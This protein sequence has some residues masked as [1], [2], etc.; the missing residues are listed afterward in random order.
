M[1]DPEERHDLAF[2]LPHVVK[3]LMEEMMQLADGMVEADEPEVLENVGVVD[4]VWVTG[5]C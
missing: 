5:W 3:E 2:E 4:G 1:L